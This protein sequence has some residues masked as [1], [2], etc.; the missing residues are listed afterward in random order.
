MKMLSLKD[1]MWG[2]AVERRIK[3]GFT[4]STT[5]ANAMERLNERELYKRKHEC[6]CNK[7]TDEKL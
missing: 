2:N 6:F 4:K 7:K 5:E 1:R 3:S